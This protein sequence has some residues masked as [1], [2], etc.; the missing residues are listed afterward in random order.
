M[1]SLAHRARLARIAFRVLVQ[2]L[3]VYAGPCFERLSKF[4]LRA[5]C[6][7]GRS[8]KSQASESVPTRTFQ[9]DDVTRLLRCPARCSLTR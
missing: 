3:H 2:F 5:E 7:A 8:A 1:A 4:R 9:A 6:P